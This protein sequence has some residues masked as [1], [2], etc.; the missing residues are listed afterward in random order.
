MTS[1]SWAARVLADA[2]DHLIARHPNDGTQRKRRIDLL[3]YLEARG[4]HPTLL[5][6]EQERR[7][8]KV[9]VPPGILKS[10]SD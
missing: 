4:A 10:A 9:G 5:E 8:R 2:P 7:R 6:L 3:A 1:S